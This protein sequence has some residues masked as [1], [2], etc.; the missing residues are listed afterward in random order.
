MLLKTFDEARKIKGKPV[1]MICKTFKGQG[2]PGISDQENWHGKPLGAKASE[3][4]SFLEKQLV[5]TSGKL[6]PLKPI[7]DCLQLNLLGN[8]KLPSPPSYKLGDQVS[9]AVFNFIINN[10]NIITYHCLGAP[11]DLRL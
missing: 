1:A 9:N 10:M 4:I 5:V 7:E 11:N 2:F 3:V 8:I 6:V